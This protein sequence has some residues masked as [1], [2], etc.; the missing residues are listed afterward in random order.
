MPGLSWMDVFS[1]YGRDILKSAELDAMRSDSRV[2]GNRS[3]R[4][5]RTKVIDGFE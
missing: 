1:E 4:I 2:T 5:G 3:R